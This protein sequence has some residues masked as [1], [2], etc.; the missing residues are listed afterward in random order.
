[1]E[2]NIKK[3]GTATTLEEYVCNNWGINSLNDANEWYRME[4]ANAFALD[5]KKV[6][7]I[8]S[9]I[10]KYKKIT[11]MGDYDGDGVTAATIIKKYL[12]SIGKEVKV[13]IPNRFTEGFGMNRR[14]VDEAFGKLIITVDN[15]IAQ[16]DAVN[17]AAEKGMH[18]IVTDHHLPVSNEAGETILPN[19][20][21]IVDPQALP[22][23]SIFQ[24]RCGAGIA[25][26][27]VKD[28]I[29]PEPKDYEKILL[30]ELLC[31]CAIGTVTD[32]MPIRSVNYYYVRKGMDIMKSDYCPVGIKALLN[33]LAI[34]NLTSKDI[35][36]GIGP[37]IN[38]ASR[39][40]DDGA[41]CALNLLCTDNMLDANIWAEDMNK[42]NVIRKE[43]QSLALEKA[44]EIISFTGVTFPL[45]INIP[46]SHEG[47]LGIVAGI[48]SQKYNVPTIVTTNVTINGK[49]LLKGS[50]RRPTSPNPDADI[51]KC[52]LKEHLDKISS[53]LYSYGGHE[54][55][56]GI[57]MIPEHYEKVKAALISDMSDYKIEMSEEYYDLEIRADQVADTLLIMGKFEPFGMGNPVPKFKITDFEPKLSFGSYSSLIG[58][59]RNHVRIT[60]TCGCAAIGFNMAS[61]MSPLNGEP[62]NL[63]GYLVWNYYKGNATAQVQFS[64]IDIP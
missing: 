51:N 38:A 33:E 30:R 11:I 4:F 39:M 50:G 59:E 3:R 26:Q 14:M 7:K 55:A 41:Y 25:F 62:V 44:E 42:G 36:F 61:E 18:I 32:C 49:E 57:S 12:E 40:Q 31:Y 22:T 43:Y 56:C 54:A 1:M 13:L 2:L 20:D 16:L 8:K 15:G 17:Y 47:I 63:Y 64:A 53:L 34:V 58:E 5:P 24:E 27:L 48:L 52:H 29:G 46:N 60:S 23:D 21:V 19:A 35:G 45:V 37:V 28:L 9:L 10:G 6:K